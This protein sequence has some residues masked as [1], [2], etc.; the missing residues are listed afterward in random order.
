MRRATSPAKH[1]MTCCDSESPLTRRSK[2]DSK[3]D[4]VSCMYST[5]AP[6]MHNTAPIPKGLASQIITTCG[7]A[8]RN[9]SNGHVLTRWCFRVVKNALNQSNECSICRNQMHPFGAFEP[10]SEWIAAKISLRSGLH[11]PPCIDNGRNAH[12]LAYIRT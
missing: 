8:F 12:G 1:S 3:L 4:G 6:L 7:P 5:M 2:S 9:P 10:T 11:W